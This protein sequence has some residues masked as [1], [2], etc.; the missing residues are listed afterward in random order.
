MQTERIRSPIA[1]LRGLIER[2]ALGQFVP[3]LAPRIAAERDRNCR[4]AMARSTQQAEERRLAAERATPDYQA[5]ERERKQRIG[6]LL[7]DMRCRIRASPG[8]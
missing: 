7:S 3:E 4:E 1:Y 2:A 8:R 5:R 6:E